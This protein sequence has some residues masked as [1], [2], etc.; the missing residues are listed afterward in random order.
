MR[1]GKTETG[2]KS[3]EK[4]EEEG[5]C[6][7]S[8]D[9]KIH[10]KEISI[11]NKDNKEDFAKNDK[12][13]YIL[14]NFNGQKIQVNVKRQNEDECRQPEEHSQI[15][16][17]TKSVD[18]EKEDEDK[19][20]YTE[21]KEVNIFYY[22]N[23]YIDKCSS[24]KEFLKKVIDFIIL[25]P[26]GY[27]VNNSM[28][29]PLIAQPN[30]IAGYFKGVK[31]LDYFSLPK[32]NNTHLLHKENNVVFDSCRN[33]NKTVV[34]II[35]YP[36]LEFVLSVNFDLGEFISS[37]IEDEKKEDK[38]TKDQKSKF[39]KG[40][41]EINNYIKS[42]FNTK[43]EETKSI[44][45]K[46]LSS[47][48]IKFIVNYEGEHTIV[49]S[50]KI[51]DFIELVCNTFGKIISLL[52]KLK[53]IELELKGLNIQFDYK[54]KY[55]VNDDY[56][57]LGK[58]RTICLGFKPLIEGKITIH[59]LEAML[60]AIPVAGGVIANISVWAKKIIHIAGLNNYAD[61]FIDFIA[62]GSINITDEI[63]FSTFSNETKKKELQ[64]YKIEVELKA[65]IKAKGMFGYIAAAGIKA[66]NPMLLSGI[67]NIQADLEFSGKSSLTFAGGTKPF[68]MCLSF[69]GME[70][71]SKTEC[72]VDFY[73]ISFNIGAIINKSGKPLKKTLIEPRCLIKYELDSGWTFPKENPDENEGCS[74]RKLGLRECNCIIT[75]EEAMA[76]KMAAEVKESIKNTKYILK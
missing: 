60:C 38:N 27:F 16:V 57:E 53:L 8:I 74:I 21:N 66:L 50:S 40:K 61:W 24:S 47:S 25:G 76:K 65:G 67:T 2:A 14:T 69:D 33:K 45:K 70:I 48:G 1:V 23:E 59:V 29:E 52:G 62:D 63:T 12:R 30:N 7:E 64:E 42:S 54:K 11:F 46:A 18:G 75:N 58:E 35:S 68:A 4:E 22:N 28:G 36:N 43:T 5:C 3:P 6:F 17:K 31:Y 19:Y 71:N 15:L 13:I 32:F 26:I 20:K 55:I 34:N 56:T 44:G 41:E 49:D 9:L 51:T 72:V 39:E 10:G 73:S 37:V